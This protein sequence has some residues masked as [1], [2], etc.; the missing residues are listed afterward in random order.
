MDGERKLLLIVVGVGLVCLTVLYS[1][2][3]LALWQYKELVGASLLGV[4]LLAFAVYLRGKLTEQDIRIIRF[5]HKEETP[6]D[7]NG[8][9]LYYHQ[10]FQVNPH[11]K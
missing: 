6:L 11:R 8:E 2:L 4:V 7:D 9:P 10:G 3:F 1:F 5:R